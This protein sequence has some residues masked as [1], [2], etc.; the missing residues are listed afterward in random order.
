MKKNVI[1]QATDVLGDFARLAFLALGGMFVFVA[2]VLIANLTL[3]LA[4]QVVHTLFELI[5]YIFEG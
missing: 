5:R 2:F 4:A 3:Y 1:K